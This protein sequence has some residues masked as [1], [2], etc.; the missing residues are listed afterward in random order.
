V[1]DPSDAEIDEL[2]SIDEWPTRKPPESVKFLTMKKQVIR[3]RLY[4]NYKG[5]NKIVSK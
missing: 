5:I 2:L 4:L 3:P 1:R